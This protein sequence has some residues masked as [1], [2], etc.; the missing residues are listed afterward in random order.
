MHTKSQSR[1]IGA[2]LCSIVL[3]ACALALA[4]PL[5][6]GAQGPPLPWPA[7]YCTQGQL[8]GQIILIC[9][10]PSPTADPLGG[11]N[12]VLVVYAHGYVAPQMP[13]ALPAGEL[14]QIQLPGG[15]SAVE[16]LLGQ[17]FAFATTSYSKN[18]YAVGVAEQD[19]NGLVGYFWSQVP[20]LLPPTTL[21]IGASEG[22]IITV[23]Q[24]ETYPGIYRGGLAMCGPIGGMPAQI[25]YL[26]DFR[27]I[28][29]QF[30]QN[31]FRFGAVDVPEDAYLHWGKYESTIQDVILRH[32]DKSAQL[33]Q[34]TR[35]A[36]VPAVPET[37][38][39]TAQQSLRFSVFGT[40]D[41]I[42]T[43]GGNPYDNDGLRYTGAWNDIA[44]NAKVERVEAW[45]TGPSY[46]A[47]YYQPR[48]DLQVP[49]V[50]IHNRLD[51]QVPYWHEALYKE[52]VGASPLLTQIESSVPYGH[53]SFQ[54][55]EVVKAFNALIGALMPPT[56]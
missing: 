54:A 49:L 11:W 33:F 37:W 45:G 1:V 42:A 53:C 17:G 28:F 41:M 32:P 47:A 20:V 27:V 52:L 26:G 25:Q 56:P 43:A 48:G 6:T 35:A 55:D 23:Q 29:D 51:P 22:G 50:T 18:G 3:I 16:F 40:N 13:L 12:G 10:P 24:I 36:W 7:E 34:I 39:A 15:Q 46:I 38:V 31:V 19:L 2:R 30:F 21:L 5:Q 9:L 14:G 44:L 4:L 8:G